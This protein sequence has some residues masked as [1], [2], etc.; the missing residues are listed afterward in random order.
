MGNGFSAFSGL[1]RQRVSSRSKGFLI[2]L[3]NICPPIRLQTYM[4]QTLSLVW[5]TAEQDQRI[6]EEIRRE[7][8]RSKLHPQAGGRRGDAED[9]LQDVFYELVEAYRC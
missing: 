6:S 9:I 5:M 8:R 3:Y 7:Q 4:K 2:L 1:S